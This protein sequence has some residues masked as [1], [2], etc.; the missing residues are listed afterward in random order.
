[1][2]LY[3]LIFDLF[4][5]FAHIL[6]AVCVCNSDTA[7]DFLDSLSAAT[8]IL[9]GIP[10]IRFICSTE[11]PKFARI[12]TSVSILCFSFPAL[13]GV[14]VVKN[15]PIVKYPEPNYRCWM[16]VSSM[17]EFNTDNPEVREYLLKVVKYWIKEANIDGY[18]ND[19]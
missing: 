14:C 16:G 18:S 15:Y 17:P 4:S 1:T 12:Y 8:V 9:N 10:P 19:F 5:V 7:F 3:S 11:K 2:N 13:I 6:F